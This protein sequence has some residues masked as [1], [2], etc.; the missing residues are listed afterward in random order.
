VKAKP[1]LTVFMTG[2]DA[3]AGE[4]IGITY[5]TPVVTEDN[6]PDGTKKMKSFVKDW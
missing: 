2:S 1:L 3:L 4:K 5:Y 6:T